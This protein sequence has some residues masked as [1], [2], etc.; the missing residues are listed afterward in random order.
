MLPGSAADGSREDFCYQLA[1]ELR[2]EVLQVIKE[3]HKRLRDDQRQHLQENAVS[4]EQLLRQQQQN[5]QR[6]FAAKSAPMQETSMGNRQASSATSPPPAPP[7]ALALSPRASDRHPPL[8]E[9]ELGTCAPLPLGSVGSIAGKAFGT[10]QAPKKSMT[11]QL[12]GIG[13]LMTTS[14]GRSEP[15][16]RIFTED[17]TKTITIRQDFDPVKPIGNDSGSTGVGLLGSGAGLANRSSSSSI[18]LGEDAKPDSSD[19]E[20]FKD[21]DHIVQTCFDEDGVFSLPAEF[22]ASR[23]RGNSRLSVGT[24]ASL[25]SSKQ[26]EQRNE[27]ND[28]IKTTIAEQL[29]GTKSKS[30]RYD[31]SISFSKSQKPGLVLI[32]LKIANSAAFNSYCS[33][34]V[35]LNAAFIGFDTSISMESTL[36]GRGISSWFRIAHLIFVGLFA[37]EIVL[38]VS[39]FRHSFFFGPD[40]KWNLFDL[41]LVVS[42]LCE[43]ILETMA[44]VGFLRVFRGMRMIRVLRLV[45]V[46]RVMRDLRLMVCSIFQSFISFF[47]ALMLLFVITYLAVVF[48]MQG[49]LTHLNLGEPTAEFKQE[50]ETWYRSLPIAFVTMLMCITG[51]VDWVEAIRPLGRI[52]WFYET[53]FVLYILFVVIG[54]LN[55]LTGI[56]V[57]RAQELSG[58]DRDLVIQGEMKRNE[59]FLAEMKGIFEEADTDGSG[60]ISWQEFKEYLKNAEVKAYLATQQLDAYDARQLFNILDL[61]DDQEVGIEEFIMGCMRLKGMAKSVDVVALLQESRKNNR[62]VKDFLSEVQDQLSAIQLKLGVSAD[63]EPMGANNSR[64]ASLSVRSSRRKNSFTPGMAACKDSLSRGASIRSASCAL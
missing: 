54:V 24:A 11:L 51:G 35:M 20:E 39:A 37:I 38:R 46:F 15:S 1:S 36:Q 25:D 62:K 48:F 4:I 17:D 23:F 50:V 21:S 13:G 29:A 10:R 43:E 40:C 58:L 18:S 32:L 26:E 52:H 14:A 30:V 9:A 34:V 53:I 22:E 33:A 61:E 2:S 57:E 55:V 12:P 60:T 56:F 44:P 5:L 49:S 31:R 16:K 28:H 47:W 41:A 63:V 59:A 19:D 64:R 45:R 3:E 6:A 42:S 7:P 27:W 8:D